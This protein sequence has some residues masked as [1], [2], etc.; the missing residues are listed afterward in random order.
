MKEK[1]E[2]SSSFSLFYSPPFFLQQNRSS[3]YFWSSEK[4]LWKS[5]KKIDTIRTSNSKFDSNDFKSHIKK[6]LTILFMV[7]ILHQ[8]CSCKIRFCRFTRLPPSSILCIRLLV[9]EVGRFQKKWRMSWWPG[10]KKIEVM[11]GLVPRWIRDAK[12]KPHYKSIHGQIS[13]GSQK[14]SQSKREKSPLG[15]SKS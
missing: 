15:S 10:D 3:T 13:L 7:G 6:F 8:I 14:G 5:K 2:T 9:V 11:L 4:N 12:Q 1:I